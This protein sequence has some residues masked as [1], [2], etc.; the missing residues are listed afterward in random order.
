MLFV[1]GR[2]MRDEPKERHR[3]RQNSTIIDL[4]QFG[5]HA[6]FVWL[7]IIISRELDKVNFISPEYLHYKP[8]ARNLQPILH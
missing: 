7:R 2:G 6:V 5:S 1:R 3:R 4:L 8:F